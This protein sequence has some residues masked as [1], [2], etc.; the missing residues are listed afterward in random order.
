MPPDPIILTICDMKLENASAR[1]PPAVVDVVPE[2]VVVAVVVS[3]EFVVVVLVPPAGVAVVLV[4][5]GLL[6]DDVI[7]ESGCPLPGIAAGGTDKP[8]IPML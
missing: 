1:S 5:V 7:V 6:L 8:G 4:D 3:D 2:L